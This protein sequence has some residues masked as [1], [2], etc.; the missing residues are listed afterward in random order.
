MMYFQATV[1]RKR[2][3][4]N[5]SSMGNRVRPVN[6]WEKKRMG[7]EKVCLSLPNFSVIQKLNLKFLVLRFLSNKYN[8]FDMQFQG[9]QAFSLLKLF[10]TKHWS[11]FF[12]VL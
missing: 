3:D 1:P 6:I 8:V 2:L 12:K 11:F 5:N 9:R 4:S 7:E 10:L